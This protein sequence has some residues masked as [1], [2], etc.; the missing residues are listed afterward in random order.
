MVWH[1]ALQFRRTTRHALQQQQH[2]WER[3]VHGEPHDKA[4]GL[5]V[6][7]AA[8]EE[9]GQAEGHEQNRTGPVWPWSERRSSG[10]AGGISSPSKGAATRRRDRWIP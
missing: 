10:S 5:S 8:L 1:A 4:P 7:N 3:L 9:R 6:G 2:P